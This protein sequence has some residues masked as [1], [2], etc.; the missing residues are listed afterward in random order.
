MYQRNIPYNI[1]HILSE[2]EVGQKRLTE[3]SILLF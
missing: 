2:K 3:F 1:E